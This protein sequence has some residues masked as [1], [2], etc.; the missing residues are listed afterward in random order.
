MMFAQFEINT[1]MCMRLQ[2]QV[3]YKVHEWNLPEGFGSKVVSAASF[4]VNFGGFRPH[5]GCIP[6]SMSLS[7]LDCDLNKTKY[8]I[9]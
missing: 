7:Y 8:T 2:C 5:A 1:N 4:T 6:S 3:A 9:E